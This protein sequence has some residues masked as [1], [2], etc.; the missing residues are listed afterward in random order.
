[1]KKKK[2]SF[3]A[4]RELA[5]L[6]LLGRGWTSGYELIAQLEE[7]GD[8][9][10]RNREAAIYPLLHSLVQRGMA[11]EDFLE[12]NELWL[13]CGYHITR[14]G[15]RLLKRR[16][17]AQAPKGP[18]GPGGEA[19]PL[20]ET[21]PSEAS[22][23]Q[24]GFPAWFEKLGGGLRFPGKTR[25]IEK[26]LRG[27]YEQS[28][29]SLEEEGMRFQ[30]AN[31]LA[32][33]R[34]G[35][36]RQMGALLRRTHRPVLSLCLLLARPVMLA[37]LAVVLLA[38]LRGEADNLRLLTPTQ[39]RERLYLPGYG[40]NASSYR[41]LAEREGSCDQKI[42][43]GPYRIDLEE[44]SFQLLSV[45]QYQ[46]AISDSMEHYGYL[47]LGFKGLPWYDVRSFLN[48]GTITVMDSDGNTINQRYGPWC[49]TAA[50][51]YNI[52]EVN[53]SW[54]SDEAQWLDVCLAYGD[55]REKLRVDLE[56]WRV[57]P[58]KLKPLDKEAYRVQVLSKAEKAWT[59]P[60]ST[61]PELLSEREAEPVSAG[62]EPLELGVCW[63][64]ETQYREDPERVA[65]K[66]REQEREEDPLIPQ[67]GT[68]MEC[69]LALRADP[70]EFPTSKSEFLERL[71]ISDP[72]SGRECEAH[73]GFTAP[74]W[75]AD[76]WLARLYWDAVPGADSYRI[77][78]TGK[79][80]GEQLSLRLDLKEV[81]EP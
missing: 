17:E 57:R 24:D 75:Y 46:G 7:A 43:I 33:A 49:L 41:L 6:R 67:E 64:K 1:M 72:V 14:K 79:L 70:A 34:M 66:T 40:E 11:K 69:V 31:S 61:T 56:P 32:L 8:H 37:L 39:V 23:A 4:S 50:P 68:V 54:L 71:R 12:N 45:T 20:P 47:L 36:P 48:T 29:Q 26:E 81:E 73:F 9:S 5:V 10:F 80:S 22:G 60:C 65:A 76:A 30:E 35:E 3:P 2:E 55:R 59:Y 74:E 18:G 63:A 51:G 25:R 27:H 21:A 44:A 13:R 53:I 38:V 28:I 58:E 15:S 77:E 62:T 78:Y 19:E 52:V 16:G 42:R